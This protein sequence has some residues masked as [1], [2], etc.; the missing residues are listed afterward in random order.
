MGCCSPVLAA[1][2]CQDGSQ[3]GTEGA[4]LARYMFELRNNRQADC[5]PADYLPLP[6]K[7]SL[8]VVKSCSKVR[9]VGVAPGGR[10]RAAPRP[11]RQE[12][13]PSSPQDRSAWRRKRGAQRAALRAVSS[14]RRMPLTT[15]AATGRKSWRWRRECGSAPART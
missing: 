6:K 8:Q 14:P 4:L 3:L 11:R 12:G 15:P 2:S 13:A 10:R 5:S 7:L 9:R 1:E